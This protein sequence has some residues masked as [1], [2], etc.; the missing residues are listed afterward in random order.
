MVGN[1]KDNF[2]RLPTR[3]MMIGDVIWRLSRFG[4]DRGKMEV[5]VTSVLW[6]CERNTERAFSNETKVGLVGTDDDRRY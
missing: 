5:L 3:P 2:G 4:V 1:N 6:W